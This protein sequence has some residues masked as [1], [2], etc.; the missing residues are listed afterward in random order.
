LRCAALVVAR[1][2]QAGN[3]FFQAIFI[4]MTGVG[5]NARL[6]VYTS[7]RKSVMHPVSG[8]GR[9]DGTRSLAKRIDLSTKIH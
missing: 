6:D 3:P 5:W 2:P 7:K 9:G 4:D 1:R 8:G